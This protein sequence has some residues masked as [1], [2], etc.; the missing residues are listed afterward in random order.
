MSVS[1]RVLTDRVLQLDAD[2]TR[3]GWSHREFLELA[4]AAPV[5]A[6]ELQE[7]VEIVRDAVTYMTAC[8]NWPA[9]PSEQADHER[10]KVE[11]RLIAER[12]GA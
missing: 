8:D 9:S 2:T 12:S 1:L 10:R 7:A 5:L 4:N 3:R 6:R 11:R